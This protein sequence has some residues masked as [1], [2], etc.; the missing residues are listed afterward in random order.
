M[1]CSMNTELA[2]YA[3]GSL[4]SADHA[5]VQQHL[6]DCL[7][8]RDELA[9]IAGV[10]GLLRRVAANQVGLPP[11]GRPATLTPP[12]DTRPEA[13][14]SRRSAPVGVA[15]LLRIGAILRRGKWV[16]P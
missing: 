15:V 3:L 5:L 12:A 7:A 8:C 6:A 1:T 13:G 10:L 4:S 14:W 11:A 2:S 9:D 16:R